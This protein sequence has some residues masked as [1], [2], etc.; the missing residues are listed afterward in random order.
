MP[1]LEREGLARRILTK[2]PV[3]GAFVPSEQELNQ[4]EVDKMALEMLRRRQ[5]LTE[6][7]LALREG[8]KRK[9]EEAAR[10]KIAGVSVDG[11]PTIQRPQVP[12]QKPL[13]SLNQFLEKYA[14]DHGIGAG[15]QIPTF[16]EAQDITALRSTEA[17]A[18]MRG[19]QSEK[20]LNDP[21]RKTVGE[22]FPGLD[23]AK[24]S[25]QFGEGVTTN[26]PYVS[27]LQ[28][29]KLNMQ[30]NKFEKMFPVSA[31]SLEGQRAAAN[32]GLPDYIPEST[33]RIINGSNPIRIPTADEITSMSTAASI[34]DK[35]DQVANLLPSVEDKALGF[36]TYQINKYGQYV[37]FIKSDPNVVD[38][39]TNIN[40]VNNA[41]IYYM[42]GKQINEQESQRIKSEMLEPE[43]NKDAFKQRLKTVVRNWSYLRTLR[44][45]SISEVGKRTPEITN[46]RSSG[47]SM[48]I[49]DKAS[50][51]DLMLQKLLNENKR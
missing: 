5:P 40:S 18:G 15:G 13:N 41:L 30:R 9:L 44:E 11:E 34:D 14:Q 24:V 42:S 16:R 39:Y 20:I 21:S 46:T 50:E 27:A 35:I 37:P 2:L 17:L 31:L 8:N 10:R 4:N 6:E 25:D 29:G 19:V 48:N 38:F 45:K 49:E 51:S 47:T 12:E 23:D 28:I 43:L 36:G 3:L 7:Q 32:A 22:M 1:M 33:A 26:T